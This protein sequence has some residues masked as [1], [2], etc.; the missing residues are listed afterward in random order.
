MTTRVLIACPHLQRELH[1]FEHRFAAFG[2]EVEAPE[3]HQQLSEEYLLANIDRFD[4][5]VAGDDPFTAAV[6]ERAGRLRVIAKWGIGVDNIDLAAAA[7]RGIQ[8]LNTPG[9]LSAE[10]ADVTIGYLILLTRQLHRID[11]AVRGGTWAQM[12]GASLAGKRLGIVG[13]GGIGS[14]VAKRALAHDM[15]V[16]GFD[17]YLKDVAAIQTMGVEVCDLHTLLETSDFVSLNC[18]LTPETLH[19]MGEAQ[20]A[21]MKR[22]AYLI[23]TSR[24]ALVDEPYLLAA[25]ESGHIAGAAL[26]VFEV[27]PLQLDNPLHRFE[28]CIFGAHNSSNTQDAVDRIN[29]LAVENVLSVLVEAR[30]WAA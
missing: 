25:L 3:V 11:A 1:L 16:C 27:E 18:S 6:L 14:A 12:R 7:E 19:L 15:A 29:A 17:P 9:Q 8:V 10:V 13:L 30:A 23:N 5:V 28:Q 2:I 22:G 4:G 24:G 26:D 20:F 21:R